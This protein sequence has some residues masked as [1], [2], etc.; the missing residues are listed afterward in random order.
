MHK[1]VS[2]T[3]HP[4]HCCH[5]AALSTA[6]LLVLLHLQCAGQLKL[7]SRLKYLGSQTAFS[8]YCYNKDLPWHSLCIKHWLGS[9]TL[10]KGK[11][12]ACSTLIQKTSHINM[13][14]GLD[15]PLLP[16]GKVAT[17][18]QCYGMGKL[19][20]SPIR[21]SMLPPSY[22]LSL[23]FLQKPELI[24]LAV[25]LQAKLGLRAGQMTLLC[26]FHFA[27]IGC[28][29]A[30]PF[31]HMKSARVLPTDHVPQ[32]LLDQFLTYSKDDLTPI[33]PWTTAQYRAKFKALATS[34]GFTQ[35]SHSARHT[36]AS[37]Q[38]FKGDPL[39]VIS[40]MLIH[41]G[42]K[43]VYNYTHPICAQ[44]QKVIMRHPDYFRNLS[45]RIN[46]YR[47]FT[48]Q[49]Q[50]R[51]RITGIGIVPSTQAELALGENI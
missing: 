44:E 31:K 33:L 48:L 15:P 51:V 30:Q 32:W 22:F 47:A 11:P 46:A 4:P 39:K 36:F 23:S 17:A 3:H 8:E 14:T 1:P 28:L 27:T 7:V 35:A 21:V 16:G 42:D 50:Q 43:T 34:Y 9:Q 49:L 24:H 6:R 10:E 29:L 19:L 12:L 40:F 20:G 18:H 26:G 38:M 41:K 5:S 37:V 2:L 45:L 13:L 25:Q